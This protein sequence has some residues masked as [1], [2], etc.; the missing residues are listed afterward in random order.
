MR[1]ARIS[2]T[3]CPCAVRRHQ[4]GGDS[5][6]REVPVW[7][8][9]NDPEDRKIAAREVEKSSDKSYY[10]Y[11]RRHSLILLFVEKDR[12]IHDALSAR[13]LCRSVGKSARHHGD[14]RI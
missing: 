13:S 6:A 3:G 8:Q 7:A 4:N 9:P 14:P 2:H 12:E 1:T 10:L 11:N 5:A